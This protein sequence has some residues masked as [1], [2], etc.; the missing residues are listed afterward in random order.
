MIYITYPQNTPEE[1]KRVFL[2]L[3]ED[4]DITTPE[5]RCQLPK[6]K[7]IEKS[8]ELLE[9]SSIFIA[10]SSQENP[11]IEIEVKKAH[12]NKIPIV[13][14]VKKGQDYPKSI[15]DIYMKVIK[16]SNPG[17]LSA[18]LLNFLNEEFLEE[19]KKEYFKYDEFPKTE[20]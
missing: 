8:Q 9:N 12:N 17:D 20:K 16:Y 13:L 7:F 1:I 3:S 4:F 18:K 2:S 11:G 19:S 15:K 10:E 5:D 6:D 14:F